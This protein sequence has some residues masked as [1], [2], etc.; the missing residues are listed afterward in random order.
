MK[1]SK[2]KLQIQRRECI[3][4]QLFLSEFYSADDK[5]AH[6][7]LFLE[8]SDLL[9]ELELDSIEEMSHEERSLLRE[10]CEKIVSLLP[11]LDE[12]IN[13]V[14]EGWKTKRMSRVDLS[15]I[16]L[17]LYEMLYDR[18]IPYKVAINEAVELAKKYG[19]SESPA[20]VNAILGKLAADLPEDGAADAPEAEK[21][22]GK[23]DGSAGEN[24]K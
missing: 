7:S 1:S 12:K 3:F 4:Q 21:E 22:A 13:A 23:H 2:K 14:S 18:E 20:F 11:E 6:F 8:D 17:A 24:L 5:P 19:G 16:R 9:N 10:R 15:L